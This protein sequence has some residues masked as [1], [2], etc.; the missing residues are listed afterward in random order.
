MTPSTPFLPVRRGK[1][2]ALLFGVLTGLG[3]AGSAAAQAT[4]PASAAP[5]PMVGMPAVQSSTAGFSYLSG[6]AGTEERQAMD[7]RRGQFPIKV[8]LSAGK[9]EFIVAEKLSL[10]TAQGEV[11]V[12]RDAGP[13]VMIQAPA[14]AYTLVVSY[15]GRTERRPVRQATQVQTLN[16][17]FPG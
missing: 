3:L 7:A 16:L 6:G 14:G 2:P 8:V 5:D 12:V 9:G 11:L 13:V 17:R 15:Q 1:L 10:V 4:A